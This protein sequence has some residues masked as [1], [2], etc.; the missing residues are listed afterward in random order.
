MQGSSQTRKSNKSVEIKV[1]SKDSKSIDWAGGPA[2]LYVFK[3]PRQVQSAA[4]LGTITP[5]INEAH[6]GF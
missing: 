1:M 2:N 4:E 3:M 6:W 5:G